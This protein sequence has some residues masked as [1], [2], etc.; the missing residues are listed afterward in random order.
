MGLG[1]GL[2]ADT[3]PLLVWW[4]AFPPLPWNGKGTSGC[5]R[6]P[7]D[8]NF[9]DKCSYPCDMV[10][11]PYVPALEGGC[12]FSYCRSYD[13]WSSLPPVICQLE[14]SGKWPDELDAVGK[15]KSAFYIKMHKLLGQR[16]VLSSPTVD[17]IDILMVCV[18]VCV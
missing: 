7:E 6:A 10:L 3:L 11:P 5:L 18:C 1:R 16:C 4:Q 8:V 17:Y 2:I 14:A 9:Q 13:H 15:I 12:G